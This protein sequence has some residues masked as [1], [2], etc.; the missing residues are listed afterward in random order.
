ML[1]LFVFLTPCPW[2]CSRGYSNRL[3]LCPTDSLATRYITHALSP[4]PNSPLKALPSPDGSCRNY[5]CMFVC[6]SLAWPLVILC[7]RKPVTFFFS[8][9]HW[10]DYCQHPV[11]KCW[12]A[13]GKGKRAFHGYP[14]FPFQSWPNQIIHTWLYSIKQKPLCVIDNPLSREGLFHGYRICFMRFQA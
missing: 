4:P 6:V 7:L 12:W 3:K 10:C 11:P 13:L 1:N 9:P 2:I 8:V 5:I 14:D